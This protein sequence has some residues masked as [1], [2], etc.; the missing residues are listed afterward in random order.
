M[1][2]GAVAATDVVVRFNDCING[3]DLDG[4]SALM[5]DDHT[6]VD[7]AGGAVV[8]RRACREAWRGFFAAYPDYRNVFTSMSVVG[9]V[10]TVVGSRCVRIRCW[11][12][13][14]SGR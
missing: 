8:G 4:L 9:D 5:S 3:R 14:R 7:S 10:V 6:F 13:R 2:E 12:G 11:P 1:G